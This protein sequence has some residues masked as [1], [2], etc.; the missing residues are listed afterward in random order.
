LSRDSGRVGGAAKLLEPE[1][2]KKAGADSDQAQCLEPGR[3][4][5]PLPLDADGDREDRGDD[6]AKREVGVA[7]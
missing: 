5:V 3:V 6:Q 4:A 1:C 2:G 7:V